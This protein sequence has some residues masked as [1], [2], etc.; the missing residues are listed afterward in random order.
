MRIL[1]PNTCRHPCGR[2]RRLSRRWLEIGGLVVRTSDVWRRGRIFWVCGSS[3]P[4]LLYA[5]RFKVLRALVLISN[6]APATHLASLIPPTACLSTAPSVPRIAH[7]L[8]RSG[9][10]IE[11]IAYSACL[12]DALTPRFAPAW[13]AA[14][15]DITSPNPAS[16]VPTLRRTTKQPLPLA[17]ELIVLAAL[18]ITSSYHQDHS[19]SKEFWIRVVAE[20][21]FETRQLNRTISVVL[22][23]LGYRLQMFG[24]ERVEEMVGAM[25]GMEKGK[26]LER[27]GEGIGL[28]GKRERPAVM[29][30][31]NA[32]VGLGIAV[33]M[34]GVWTPE[35]SP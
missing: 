30:G 14:C 20:E 21:R 8:A 27:K 24:P 28:K 9:L 2:R 31:L 5:L 1:R 18:S 11:L 16:A 22:Q 3:I 34:N 19:F 4:L 17:P 6:T 7:Y 13:F 33:W 23:D 12:L 25:R 29:T 35:P 10:P 15:R 32:G 26:E